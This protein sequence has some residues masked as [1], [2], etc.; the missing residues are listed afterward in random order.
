MQSDAEPAEDGNLV[1]LT[2]SEAFAEIVK[3]GRVDELTLTIYYANP[4]ILYADPLTVNTLVHVLPYKEG[5]SKGYKIVI[6]GSRL[7]EHM[8]LLNQLINTHLIPIESE[9]YVDAHVYY[10]F[11]TEKDGELFDVVVWGMYR[12]EEGRYSNSCVFVNG[13]AVNG[14]HDL[15][16]II[17]FIPEDI[18]Q[19]YFL[20]R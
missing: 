16:V 7:E 12:N 2:G 20:K 19:S 8:D 15:D 5:N 13:I 1:E 10:V 4:A 6:E 11:E 17:P 14:N 9:S 18:A 3:S